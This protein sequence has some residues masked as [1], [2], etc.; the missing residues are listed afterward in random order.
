M[1]CGSTLAERSEA[2]ESSMAFAIQALD[3]SFKRIVPQK[4]AFAVAL[5]AE[6]FRRYPE[7]KML[8]ERR[9]TDITRQYVV[10]MHA[11]EMVIGLLK[12][13]EPELLEATLARVGRQHREYGVQ[14][15]DFH[16][17]GGVLFDTLEQFDPEWS[18]ELRHDWQEAYDVVIELMNRKA[19]IVTT[20]H[21]GRS[22]GEA[23]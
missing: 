6:M 8:F 17:V 21:G 14:H 10:L 1:V 19:T 2:K 5:Y 22:I 15:V 12:G 20:T 11:L 13:N 7:L 4:Q 16:H 9:Q 18:P 23:L 3:D